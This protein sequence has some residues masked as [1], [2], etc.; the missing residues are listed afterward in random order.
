MIWLALSAQSLLYLVLG[1][2]G[3]AVVG[4]AM[5]AGFY[6]ESKQPGATFGFRPLKE[7]VT[8]GFWRVSRYVALVGA[9]IG[10]AIVAVNIL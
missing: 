7:P 10:A 6:V 1:A 5:Y 8:D 3:G 4:W 9:L 2:I